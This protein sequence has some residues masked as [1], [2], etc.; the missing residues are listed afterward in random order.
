MYSTEAKIRQEAGFQSNNNVTS[1][2][3]TQYQTRA[4]NL[5]RSYVAGRY[6]L[7]QLAGSNFTGSQAESVL[8]QCELLLA[9]GYLISSEFQGQPRGENEGKGKIADAMSILKQITA[10]E[11]RLVGVDGSEFTSGGVAQEQS[12][13]PEYTAPTRLNAN[14]ESSEKSFSVNDRF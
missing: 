7:S 12:G 3:V 9:A 1:T 2:T 4:Y 8:E 5:V 11:L 6:D 14:P 10:G 13:A